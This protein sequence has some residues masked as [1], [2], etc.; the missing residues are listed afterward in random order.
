MNNSKVITLLI[1]L[2]AF[3]SCADKKESN[4]Q[5]LEKN[6]TSYSEKYQLSE[7]NKVSFPLDSF[8][9]FWHYSTNFKQSNTDF[10]Y[11][12]SFLNEYNKKIVYYD[13]ESK[14]AKYI[15]LEEDGENGVGKLS[16]ASAHLFVNPNEWYVYNENS[17]NLYKID[18]IGQVLDKFEIADYKTTK[19]VPFPQ[20]SVF[21]PM[22]M[23]DNQI[24][25]SCALNR[26]QKEYDDYGMI[27][28]YDLLTRKG[29]YIMPFPSIYNE[30]FWGSSFKYMNHIEYN[31][32]EKNFLLNYP[33][34]P[35][36]I[37]TDK[38]GNTIESHL[39]ESKHFQ[40]FE[41]MTL[42]LDYALD[43]N[44][45]DYAKEKAYSLSNSDF[46]KIIYD[47]FRN[48]YYRICFIRPS[49]EEVKS[50]RTV[51]DFSVIILDENFKK[52]GEQKFSSN[53]FDNSMIFCL[54]E[55]LALARKDLY[56]KNEEA[57][58]F[59]IYGLTPKE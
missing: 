45:R 19:D 48:M 53:D 34:S 28:K 20:P 33:I 52:L 43:R 10:K 49:L 12:F 29:E 17:A 7:I 55:G 18:S 35:Y 46:S 8:S 13:L 38:E 47:S 56:N 40:K 23:V 14:R 50:G 25:F 27:L 41:P 44:K 11:Y 30:G 42:D 32:K 51:S 6:R 5:Y 2:S 54:E 31:D 58:T 37:K 9:A 4:S 36:I 39:V 57:V 16:G 1:I 59:S 26:P 3:L 15:A 22:L 21:N 24:Y